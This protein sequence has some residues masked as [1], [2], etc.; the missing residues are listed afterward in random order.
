[1]ADRFLEIT[2]TIPKNK[3][4]PQVLDR[5]D[6]ERE[7]GIT[8][9]LQPVR[10]EFLG[11]ILNLIDTP[12]HM[13]FYLE[14]KR[15]LSAVEGA[16]LLVDAVKG[17]QAQTLS[18][19]ELALNLGLEIIPVINKIDLPNAEISRVEKE[20][21]QILPQKEIFKVSAKTGL[22]VE[23]LLK[24]AIKKIPE[25]K[26]QGE[27]IIF[28]NFYDSYHGVVN[29]VRI[30]NNP[31]KSRVGVFKPDM[32]PTDILNSGDIGYVL[33]GQK[34]SLKTKSDVQP[35]VFAGFFSDDFNLLEDALRKL[36]LNDKAISIEPASWPTLGRGF[37]CGFLGLLHLE[38]ATERLKREFGVDLIVTAPQIGLKNGQEPWVELEIISPQEYLGKI[39]SLLN[40]YRGD[41]RETKNLSQNRLI[42]V[43]HVPFYE[44]ITNFV[45]KLK[46]ASSGFASMSYRFLG[47]RDSEL[48]KVD[49]LLSGEK[50]DAFSRYLPK[51]RLYRECKQLVEKLKKVLPRQNFAV[52]IQAVAGSRVIARETIKAFRKDVIAGL[53]GGDYTRKKKLLEKQKKGKKRMQKIG[54]IHL[55]S[56]VFIKALKY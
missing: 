1:M 49:I 36:Q 22:G 33:T 54:R 26:I 10:M 7:K 45:D 35:L 5:M 6:L 24:A 2:N 48:E 41:L 55:S 23:E 13:D 38:I 4:K 27:N 46:S 37:R 19:L 18:N 29:F 42:L 34:V 20:I 15:S 8:I 12:G 21:Q 39:I 3:M 32:T 52:A 44:I 50:I 25:P 9:K 40:N 56:E 28:D 43:S 47:W 11:Y 31:L 16:I 53:Y 14:V 17:V 30:N 51:V